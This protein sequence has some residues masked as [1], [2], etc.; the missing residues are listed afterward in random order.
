MKTVKTLTR[1]YLQRTARNIFTFGYGAPKIDQFGVEGGTEY[2]I[3][4]KG[5][6]Y[7]KVVG[8]FNKFYLFTTLN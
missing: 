7:R 2:F 5:E 8:D 1:S 3:T 6:V 4:S